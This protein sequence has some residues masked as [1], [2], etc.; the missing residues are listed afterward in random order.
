MS[1]VSH[2]INAKG[3]LEIRELLGS[4]VVSDWRQADAALKRAVKMLLL[5]RPD[6]LANYF[7]PEAWGRIQTLPRPDQARIVLAAFKAVVVEENGVP[8]ITHWAQA[9]F[10]MNT[11]DPRF[12]NLAETWSAAHP[13][14]CPYP[15]RRKH[16]TRL[17]GD[18]GLTADESPDRSS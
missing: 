17:L 12:I 2:L 15:L 10:Y 16:G 8:E 11:R 13:E 9:L 6:L 14:Q 4:P 18:W 1:P 3:R 5:T 7:H